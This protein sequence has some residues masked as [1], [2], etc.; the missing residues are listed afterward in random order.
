MEGLL[1]FL[2]VFFFSD[3]IT[4]VVAQREFLLNYVWIYCTQLEYIFVRQPN[5]CNNLLVVY[6]HIF[7]NFNLHQYNLTY[8]NLCLYFLEI[9]FITSYILAKP[10]SVRTS[11]YRLKIL[12]AYVHYYIRFIISELF[13]QHFSV[14]FK[15]TPIPHFV[16]LF[17]LNS[18]L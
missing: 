4:V 6:S 7:Y 14:F 9:I 3:T 2:F 16:S 18:I 11:M 12:F 8:I 1:I 15:W 13:F 5:Y 17:V 10:K